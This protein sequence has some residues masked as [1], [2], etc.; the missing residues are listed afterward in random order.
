MPVSR[1]S[2]HAGVQEV[3]PCQCPGI[4][5][6]DVHDTTGIIRYELAVGTKP[7]PTDLAT[8][9]HSRRGAL[10]ETPCSDMFTEICKARICEQ[11]RDDPDKLLHETNSI[12]PL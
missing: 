5:S 4:P 7:F 6:C 11:V 9:D 3:L 10:L 1:K 12:I 8:L 2:F